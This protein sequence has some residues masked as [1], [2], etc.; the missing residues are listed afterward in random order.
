[1]C[2][3]GTDNRLLFDRGIAG[4]NHG[5][6]NYCSNR[7]GINDDSAWVE[8][9]DEMG[10]LGILE[11]LANNDD[12]ELYSGVDTGGIAGFSDGVISRCT[13]TGTVGY[14]HTGYNIGGIAG[15]QSGIVSLSTNNGTVYGRKDV[16][17]IVGQMEPFIEIDEAESLRNAIDKLHDIIERR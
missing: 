1:M 4:I 9:D 2:R 14:E 5:A 8:E 6:L 16:G 13:N 3:K 11:S 7:A 10:G 12:N 15:R 17:G